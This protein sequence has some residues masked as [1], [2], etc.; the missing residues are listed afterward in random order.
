MA[1]IRTVAATDGEGRADYCPEPSSH[2][3]MYIQ[4]MSKRCTNNI[5][6]YGGIVGGK[7]IYKSLELMFTNSGSQSRFVLQNG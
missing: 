2:V 6:I 5:Q 1:G 3:C 7:G 4:L